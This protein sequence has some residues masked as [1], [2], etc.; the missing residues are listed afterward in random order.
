MSAFSDHKSGDAIE[1][2]TE[3][4]GLKSQS[5]GRG[6]SRSQRQK[7]WLRRIFFQALGVAW[8]VPA[9]TL[10]VLNFKHFIVGAS[11]GCHGERCSL[12]LAQPDYF[13]KT[14][15]L[16]RLDHNALGTLQ[17]ASKVME[18]WFVMV[19]ASVVYDLAILLA[20]HGGLP[21]GLFTAEAEFG[22][23]RFLFNPELWTSPMPIQKTGTKKERTGTARLYGFSILVAILC[24]VV[25]LMG[26]A[27][28]V[29]ILPTLQ[30]IDRPAQPG[31]T[32]DRLAADAAPSS[33][34][35]AF[36]CN[37]ST[38]AQRDYSCTANLYAPTLDSWLA[39]Q[40]ASEKQHSENQPSGVIPSISQEGS[41]SFTFNGTRNASV[42]GTV[43]WAPNRQTLRELSD[44]YLK[45]L[46]PDGD[47]ALNNTLGALLHRP[48]PTI[49]LQIF[50]STGNVSTITLADDKQIRCYTVDSPASSLAGYS[51]CI[52]VG[53]GWSQANTHSQ[54]S[55]GDSASTVG[56]ASVNIYSTDRRNLFNS[57][58][59]LCST[60]LPTSQGQADGQCDWDKI[61]S[62]NLSRHPQLPTQGVMTLEFSTPDTPNNSSSDPNP[63][64]RAF[65]GLA[66]QSKF[67]LYAMDMS[68]NTNYLN[69]VQQTD[70]NGFS[71]HTVTVHP[72][73][74]LAGWSVRENGTVEGTRGAAEEMISSLKAALT[75]SSLPNLNHFTR[76]NLWVALQSMSMVNYASSP[77][78]A[79]DATHPALRSYATIH[80]WAYGLESRTSLMGVT[81][82]ILGCLCVLLR[83]TV[84]LATRTKR[85]SG[86]E[87]LLAALEH[88]DAGSTFAG[89][90]D[91]HRHKL[92]FVID[93]GRRGGG[94]V[95]SQGIKFMPVSSGA[96]VVGGC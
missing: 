8:L 10:L 92:R 90:K 12:N 64:R 47:S 74:I 51:E 70:L 71:N 82:V 41:V 54:F 11:I 2:T 18:V 24:V 91:S 81:V 50:C 96:V 76:T 55:I 79:P 32:F 27:T 34:N 60:I 46:Q 72:D 23:I 37:A 9:I 89:V 67:S 80:V 35:I 5:R 93:P 65:C 25:N 85:R 40:A 36:G 19:A 53:Q 21:A 83:T 15:R 58:V 61:F 26:P 42:E 1:T 88:Q 44:D 66:A 3:V 38:L 57:T 95:E 14:Q 84:G 87:L 39:S 52:R 28:A 6:R 4:G 69:I 22:D 13:A 29:L 17:I 30:W 31:P 78:S 94:G 77:S 16:D 45:T 68:P 62:S 7:A 75:N 49:G 43:F 73:W 63:N 33:E 56:N 59:P 48:G 86:V 20:R